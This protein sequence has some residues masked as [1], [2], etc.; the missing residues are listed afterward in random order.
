MR[1]ISGKFRSRQLKSPKGATCRPAMGRT[2]E[3]LFSM[4]E[5]RGVVWAN[6]RVLDVFAGSGSLSFE[7]VSRGAPF[8]LLLEHSPQILRCIND[9][10]RLL[11]VAGQVQVLSDDAL[12]ILRTPPAQPFDV[13]FL[14][15]PYHQGY[16]ERALTLLVKHGWLAPHAF[17][18]AEI[19]DKLR[20][21]FPACL[22]MVAERLFG[23]TR[24]V[25]LHC[26]EEL[27]KDAD[28]L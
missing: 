13:V 12:R 20:L 9:N 24:L 27:L 14:D 26:N 2:R 4:L 11:Q 23:Q 6:S 1:I 28:E 17:L 8:A 3:A 7:A 10:I 16:T 18:A 19:E 22:P 15:P 5:A 21:R 25:I